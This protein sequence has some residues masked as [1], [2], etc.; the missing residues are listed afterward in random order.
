MY[1]RQMRKYYII[2][3]Y[4]NRRTYYYIFLS[5]SFAIVISPSNSDSIV[6]VWGNNKSYL[7]STVVICPEYECV[8]YWFIDIIDSWTLL[9]GKTTNENTQA[10]EL[11]VPQITRNIVEKFRQL[12]SAA[13]ID[14]LLPRQLSVGQQNMKC[15]QFTNVFVFPNLL[16]LTGNIIRWLSPIRCREIASMSTKR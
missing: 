12:E 13:G 7:W 6:N 16:T 15:Y 1:N 4:N 5:K 8:A 2:Y 14:A 9:T 11:P 3:C 10:E